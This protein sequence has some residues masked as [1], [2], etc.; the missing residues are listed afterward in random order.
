MAALAVLPHLPRV[1]RAR[2]NY[3][4]QWAVPEPPHVATIRERGGF[5]AL[6]ERGGVLGPAFPQPAQRARFGARL[7]CRA[8]QSPI[9]KSPHTA[10]V[11]CEWSNP[12]CSSC[13]SKSSRRRA[14]RSS[15]TCR[16][17]RPQRRGDKPG[18]RPH[19]VT[20]TVLGHR[21]AQCTQIR[22]L[23]ET[24]FKGI[25]Q[26]AI[27][28]KRSVSGRLVDLRLSGYDAL[29][30]L[31]SIF[32]ANKP[33]TDELETDPLPQAV[34]ATLCPLWPRGRLCSLWPCI[35]CTSV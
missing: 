17:G 5:N 22:F 9:S 21:L 32:D 25:F 18:H 10:P 7:G 15:S 16:G 2:G 19:G 8:N 20:Q 12:I 31:S 13:S 14:V 26:E 6:L 23:T 3:G 30:T 1:L 33:P 29:L 4:V 34:C 11:S 24:P 35:V 28:S 27:S